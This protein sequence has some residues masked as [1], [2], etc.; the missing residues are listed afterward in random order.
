MIAAAAN[1]INDYYDIAIDRINKPHRPLPAGKISPKQARNWALLLFTAGIGTGLLVHWIAFCIA[2]TSSLLLYL[3]SYHFKRTVLWGNLIVSFVS[4]LAFIYGGVA[5]FRLR[6]AIIPAG[7]A[8]LYHLGREILKDIEDVAGDR[9]ENANTLPIRHGINPARWLISCIFFLLIFLTVLPYVYN[10][11]GRVYLFTVAMG[12]DLFL[13]YVIYSLWRD[14]SPQ[15]LHRL[16]EW[17]KLDM[18]VGLLA[19]FAGV[20]LG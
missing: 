11:F 4:G 14:A 5:V 16:S 20:Q 18:L 13:V 3:Y 1:T 19:V 12:V 2:L 10:I 8:F 9:S 6:I 15:N 7:F 17:L